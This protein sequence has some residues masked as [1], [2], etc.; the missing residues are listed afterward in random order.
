MIIKKHFQTFLFFL[1]IGFGISTNSHNSIEYLYINFNFNIRLFL[2][3]MIKSCQLYRNSKNKLCI[4]FA[5]SSIYV[6][7]QETSHLNAPVITKLS[8]PKYKSYEI[9]N[10]LE[11]AS[12]GSGHKLYINKIN[13]EILTTAQKNTTEIP[14][15]LSKSDILG[16]KLYFD[17][18]ITLGL[19]IINFSSIKHLNKILD[20]ISLEGEVNIS[21][22]FTSKHLFS[23][24]GPCISL[25]KLFGSLKIEFLPQIV[26]ITNVF[27]CNHIEDSVWNKHKTIVPMIVKQNFFRNPNNYSV[28]QF[29]IRFSHNYINKMFN[30]NKANNLFISLQLQTSA[31][32]ITSIAIGFL[33]RKNN[34]INTKKKVFNFSY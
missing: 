5:K 27:Q 14:L 29:S 16:E 7:L 22:I 8:I 30:I 10:Y 23:G 21:P 1:F 32:S 20:F 4:D 3:K 18:G 13:K 31:Y 28:M 17:N 15:F 12:N 11:N 33:Y 2:I 26:H 24:F 19:K 34:L 6:L 9:T 25:A